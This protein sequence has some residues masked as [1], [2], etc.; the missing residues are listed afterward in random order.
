MKVGL[1]RFPQ[2]S[3][4]NIFEYDVS[5]EYGGLRKKKGYL[6]KCGLGSGPSR[7]QLH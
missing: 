2:I 7:L 1:E 3:G 4:F 5:N 6:K